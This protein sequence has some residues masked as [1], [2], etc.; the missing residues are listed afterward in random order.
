MRRHCGC[1]CRLIRFAESDGKAAL[2]SI[3]VSRGSQAQVWIHDSAVCCSSIR[4]HPIAFRAAF[5]ESFDMAL[6]VF[7]ERIFLF[8]DGLHH[9]LFSSEVRLLGIRGVN[10]RSSGFHGAVALGSGDG[11]G[12]RPTACGSPLVSEM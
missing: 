4:S 6:G 8:K 10:D 9:R 1:S 5:F 3:G 2:R 12:G 7:R 11:S